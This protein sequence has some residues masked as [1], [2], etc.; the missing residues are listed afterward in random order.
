MPLRFSLRGWLACPV[1][2]QW[3]FSVSYRICWFGM[4]LLSLISYR[5]CKSK[6]GNRLAQ[7]MYIILCLQ[8]VR[9]VDYLPM[10]KLVAI[11]TLEN[12]PW[13]S[14]RQCLFLLVA[15]SSS[16]KIMTLVVNRTRS[17]ASEW[18]EIGEQGGFDLWL[19]NISSKLRANSSLTGVEILKSDDELLPKKGWPMAPEYL[20]H[21]GK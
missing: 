4:D 3:R 21:T 18:C 11:S 12:P 7:V 2:N 20:V 9:S 19:R 14:E 15:G 1:P 10:A 6:V 5:L 16:W 13:P 17:H 8:R